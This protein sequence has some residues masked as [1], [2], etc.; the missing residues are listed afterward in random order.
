MPRALGAERTTLSE[1]ASIVDGVSICAPRVWSRSAMARKTLGYSTQQ[2]FASDTGQ[3]DSNAIGHKVAVKPQARRRASRSAHRTRPW[4][5]SPPVRAARHGRQREGERDRQSWS[6]D[7]HNPK[8]R[9]IHA[10]ANS[11]RWMTDAGPRRAVG[12]VSPAESRRSRRTC[13]AE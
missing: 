4:T 12:P 11:N 3:R 9:K 6:V 1:D 7:G 13:P 2:Y 8:T 10:A 5:I